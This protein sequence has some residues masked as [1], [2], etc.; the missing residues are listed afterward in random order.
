MP[1]LETFS[2][3]ICDCSLQN[4]DRASGLVEANSGSHLLKVLDQFGT[5]LS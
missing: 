3:P 2:M 1:S 5:E 4:Y